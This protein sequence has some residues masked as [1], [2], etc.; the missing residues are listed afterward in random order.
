MKHNNDTIL[1]MA[2]ILLAKNANSYEWKLEDLKSE[3][4]REHLAWAIMI[5]KELAELEPTITHASELKRKHEYE[6]KFRKQLGAAIKKVQAG[7]PLRNPPK[8]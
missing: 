8:P 7:A 3:S 6:Q 5:A 1:L 2:A 4:V